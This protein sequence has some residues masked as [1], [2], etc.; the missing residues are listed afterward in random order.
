[1]IPITSARPGVKLAL[2]FG[3]ALLFLL[4]C[5]ACSWAGYRHGYSSA[6]DKGDKVMAELR[7]DHAD[8]VAEANAKALDR[9]TKEAER[10]NTA[11]SDLL[12]ARR[13]LATTRTLITKEIPHATAG[14]D[15][16]A[17]G[18]DFLRLYNRALGLRADPLPAPAGSG[19]AA[20]D[21]AAAAAPD[22]RLHADQPVAANAADLLTHAT[23]YGVW[24]QGVA[25]QRD[26][27]LQLL[28]EE[29]R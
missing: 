9:Y 18:P 19:G 12:T 29:A 23:D 16:C 10:A 13:S 8:A 28:T 15:A 3:L 25:A 11:A 7:R 4:A 1:M 5:L 14:L 26:A 2:Y 24:C 21:P 22:A 20:G 17:F 6:K 27:L